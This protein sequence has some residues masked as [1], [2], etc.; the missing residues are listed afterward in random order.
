[1]YKKFEKSKSY[2]QELAKIACPGDY[3]VYIFSLKNKTVH[4][5]KLKCDLLFI[6]YEL[7]LALNKLNSI[8]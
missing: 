8:S 4:N 2:P 7:Y 3:F 1:M 6:K 5:F